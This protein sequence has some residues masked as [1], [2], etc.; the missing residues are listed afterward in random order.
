MADTIVL[1]PSPGRSHLVPMVEFGKLILKHDPSFSITIIISTLPNDVAGDTSQY[2]SAVSATTAGIT[3]HHLPAVSDHDLTHYPS[4]AEVPRLRSILALQNNPNLHQTLLNLS[5]TSNVN[6][7]VIDFFCKPAV[8]VSSSLKIPAYFFYTSGATALAQIIYFPNTF[9]ETNGLKIDPETFLDIPGLPTVRAKDVF[10]PDKDGTG[11]AHKTV[12]DIAIQMTRSSGI[13]INTF[14]TLEQRAFKALKDGKCVP[15]GEKMPPIYCTGPVLA[16]G[17]DQKAEHEC[18]SWLDSQPTA[19]VVFLCFGSMGFFST[20]QLRE[21]AVGL[22][23]SGFRFLWVVRIPP[24][25]DEFRRTLAVPEPDVESFLPEGFLKRT[26]N[27]GLVVKSWAPQ[28]AVLNHDSVGGFVNHCG[29][30][31]VLEAVCAGVPMLA[32]PFVAE[33]AVNRAFLVEEIKVA[34][35][36]TVSE[37]GLVSGSELEKRVTELM[38]SDN[39]KALRER[40]KGMKEQARLALKEGGCSQVALLSWLSHL[41]KG[42]VETS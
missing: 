42:R 8:Q 5:K 32:W 6:A 41:K 38:E 30:N 18:L 9:E 2:I 24:P 27:R 31:S 39:G 26:K 40:I 12:I 10:L 33:Q 14:E 4:I 34:L 37:E 7:L 15:Y 17:S 13:I 28:L 19:S 25:G 1:Y 3:F 21:M 20:K 16:T 29:W 35:A 36:V 23:T 11:R 22:E